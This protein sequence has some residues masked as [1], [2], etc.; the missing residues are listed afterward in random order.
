MMRFIP[1]KYLTI[2][3]KQWELFFK[4]SKWPVLSM[5]IVLSATFSNI[6]ADF[7]HQMSGEF[8]YCLCCMQH[9]NHL[10]LLESLHIKN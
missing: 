8:M 5:I 10:S 4:S 9:Y 7:T 1:M 3:N 2:E 6:S